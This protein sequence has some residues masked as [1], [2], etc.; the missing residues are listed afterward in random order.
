MEDILQGKPFD[1][2]VERAM[3]ASFDE[4]ISLVSLLL[5][6]LNTRFA[7]ARKAD[8]VTDACYQ[9]LRTFKRA[10]SDPAQDQSPA[11]L[12]AAQCKAYRARLETGRTEGTMP[13]EEI[14]TRT[15]AAKLLDR[16]AEPLARCTS[17]DEAF[18]TVRTAFN[19]QVRRRE[20]AVANAGDALECAFDFMERALPDGQ[21]MVVFVNE[22]A[23]GPDSAPYLADNECE[24]F[25]Q[26]SKR[27]L[28]H[29]GE[30]ELLAELE[31]RGLTRE[32][33]FGGK[34]GFTRM[35]RRQTE[36]KNNSWAIRWNASL[37]LKDIL[38]L[39]T[40]RSLVQNTGFDGSGTNCGGG[41]LYQSRL[42]TTPI[43]VTKI[44]PVT[45]NREAR[46]AY[47]HYY[48]RTNSFM[49]KAIRRLKRTL[50]GDFGA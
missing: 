40:G 27:L 33:D 9:Q 47:A 50:K 3:D 31:R 11:A 21:E 28:L 25:E 1:A 6:G 7:A 15:R 13:A 44:S 45:E 2:V 12:F 46:A 43:P 35:L 37:F 5:A 24:R 39:N 36:G 10:L 23:L 26:Y 17:G 42:C 20:E 18:D 38:S 30:D 48:A 41:N 32:F 4:R 16:W 14:A 49:A 22:L 19:Q 8:A 29:Q 34:Y